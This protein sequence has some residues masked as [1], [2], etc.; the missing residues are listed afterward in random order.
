MAAAAGPKPP[1]EAISTSPTPK[2]PAAGSAP[3]LLRAAPART[4][5]TSPEAGTVEAE[6]R[7]WVRSLRDGATR[8][9]AASRLRA[10]LLRASQFEVARRRAALVHYDAELNEVAQAAAADALTMVVACLDDY[11]CT[12]CFTTWASKFAVLETSVTLRKLSWRERKSR[13]EDPECSLDPALPR[14]LRA[15]FEKAIG[16][17]L[18]P[19]Q[20]DVFETI[21]LK[22]VPIDVLA[23]ELRTSRA[24]VYDTLRDARTALRQ[25]LGLTAA[26]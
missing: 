26:G 6:S 16:E 5:T 17:V 9:E 3:A 4:H 19:H 22:G 21:A 2:H 11:R 10:L 23:D 15:G 20:R 24:I 14:E 25:H 13:L 7:E 8:D 1:A 12:S 18:T